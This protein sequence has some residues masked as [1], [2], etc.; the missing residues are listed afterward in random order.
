MTSEMGRLLTRPREE[1]KGLLGRPIKRKEDRRYLT[2]SSQFVDD[3]RLPEMLHAAVS[4]S[5]YPRA[6]IMSLNVERAAS[7]PGVRLVLTGKDLLQR[8]MTMPVTKPNANRRSV[9]RPVLALDKINYQGEAIAFVVADSRNI[10][11]DSAELIKIDYES[12]KPITDPSRSL[13]K[14][15][16]RIHD[17][18]ESNVVNHYGKSSGEIEKYFK[19]ADRIVRVEL[20]N[21]RITASPIEPRGIVASYDKGN[22]HLTIWMGTQCPYE[23]RNTLADL[24]GLDEMKVRVIA[25][26]IGGGFG[27]KFAVYPEDILVCF[28]SMK[29][30]R[31]VKW[32]ESRSENFATMT[33]ARGQKQIIEAAV[34][35]DGKILGIK[36]KIVSETGAYPTEEA[37]A[38]PE[39]TID[40]IPAMYDLKCFQG[41]LFCVLTNKVP[42]DAYRGAGRPE[43]TYLIERTIHRIANELGLDQTEI[44]LRNF[45]AKEK[46]PF[47]TLSGF[48]YDSGD[49][50][51]NFKKALEF[52]DYNK[53]RLEQRRL[54]ADKKR[55]TLLGI[56]ITSYVEICSFGPDFPETASLLVNQSGKVKLISGTSPHGQGHETP[57]AQIVAD[58]LGIEIDHIVVQYNDTAILPYGTFTAGSRSAAL[59]GTAVLMCARKVKQKMA[60]IAAHDLG[61][62]PFSLTFENS[63]IF[64]DE[65]ENTKSLL[66]KDV[67]N[68]AYQPTKLPKGMEPTLFAY[69]AYAPSNYT[70]P[71][72]THIAIVDVEIETGKVRIIDY[73]AVDD[74]GKIL[75]S[76]IVEG[77]AHGGILQ[78]AGQALLES[79]RYDENGQLLTSS[80]LDY[81]IPLA[82]DTLPI[83]WFRTETPS[84][85]NPLGV[86]G[87]GEAGAIAC[88]P[89]IVNAVE[90]ALLPL[91]VKLEA[92][93]LTP[94]YLRALIQASH[95]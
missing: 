21:Q 11:E 22:D 50:E 78:G 86:K 44:R 17:T 61:V 81:Q 53:W 58:E 74:C 18:L 71:F 56:G 82:E 93:P 34:K 35:N 6:R 15:S 73:L 37:V 79:V 29:L 85:V 14:D 89:T 36:V 26:D 38:E 55:G 49:Y 59:G 28:A 31:P 46:F 62:S 20:V 48:E 69:S 12:L 13:E 24:L 92:M 2:G 95:Q 52:A 67:A 43:A 65:N 40:M 42:L 25:P 76:M 32:I 80:F 72:G 27:A 33:H 83:R 9:P 51:T 45:V 23:I 60:E 84:P 41:E 63:K 10:A 8:K 94:Q 47:K 90:D 4:R 91:G 57:F 1:T 5:P 70:F 88:P 75:N 7:E 87:I 19:E 64:Q 30:G 16:P 3:I 54:R 39:I 68:I 77:Q 66:F